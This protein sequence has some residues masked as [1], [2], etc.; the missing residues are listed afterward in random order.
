M[1]L[2]CLG[3]SVFAMFSVLSFNASIY[4]IKQFQ[5]KGRVWHLFGTSFNGTETLWVISSIYVDLEFHVHFS[6]SSIILGN[7]W[8][9]IGWCLCLLEGIW[10]CPGVFL[11]VITGGATAGS[12]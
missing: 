8:L 1:V 3:L 12:L 2:Q 4:F 7:Q 6:N 10:S 11:V 5:H 9:S